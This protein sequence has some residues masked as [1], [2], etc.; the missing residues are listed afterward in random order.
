MAIIIFFIHSL[1]LPKMIVYTNNKGE[2]KQNI[3]FQCGQNAMNILNV[4]LFINQFF[5]LA[6]SMHNKHCPKAVYY[7]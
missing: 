5:Q 2:F 7:I 4:K 1:H 3:I 6:A